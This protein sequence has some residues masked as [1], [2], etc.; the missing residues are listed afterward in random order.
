MRIVFAG[1]PEPAVIALEKLLASEHEVLGVITRPDAPKGRGRTL[2]PSPV[3]LL[4]E[5]QGIPVFKPSSLRADTADGQEIRDILDSLKPACIPVV[6]YGNLISPDL[7]DIAPFGWVNV[8]FSLLP[9]W[10]GAAPVQAAIKEGD[11]VTGASV[12]RIEQGLDTG[13]VISQIE[14]SISLQDTADDLLSRLAYKGADLLVETLTD[15]D[16]GRAKLSPQEGVATYAPKVA[17]E[18]ARINW[19]AS[20]EEIQR[21]IRAYTPAPGA[22]TVMGDKRIKIGPVGFYDTDQDVDTTP[23][24]VSTVKSG[25]YVGTGTEPIKLGSIQVP[26]KKMM[27][28]SDWARGIHDKVVFN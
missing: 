27:P 26:G 11:S 18:D 1:T 22:W 21:L 6:A 19:Y 12:F 17:K 16:A 24:A 10:R 15:L 8:H 4:C 13:P 25:V 23:G 28:A 7:L 5:Q 9:R 20:A 3:G 2:S 14:E